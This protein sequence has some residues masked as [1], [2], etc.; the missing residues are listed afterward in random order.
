MGVDEGKLIKQVETY[1]HIGNRHPHK[2]RILK[3]PHEEYQFP[4]LV[5]RAQYPEDNVIFVWDK[6][7]KSSPTICL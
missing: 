2:K 1:I 5:S 7:R 3:Y 6:K 4:W